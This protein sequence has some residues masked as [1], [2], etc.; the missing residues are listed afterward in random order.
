MH[1]V[2]FTP[3]DRKVKPRK[4]ARTANV[5]T[6]FGMAVVVSFLVGISIGLVVVRNMAG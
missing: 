1:H 4:Q 5:L 6:V 2:P 3:L